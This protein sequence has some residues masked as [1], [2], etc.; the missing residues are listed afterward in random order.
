MRAA[1]QAANA[2]RPKGTIEGNGR[3][4]QIYTQTT[5]RPHRG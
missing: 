3:R 4:F 2:N 1:I 5:A